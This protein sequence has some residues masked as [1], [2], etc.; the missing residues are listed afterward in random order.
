MR[1]A[2]SANCFHFFEKNLDD[3]AESVTVALASGTN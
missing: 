1:A 3:S 2:D